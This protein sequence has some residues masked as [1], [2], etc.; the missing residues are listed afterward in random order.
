VIYL[1]YNASTPIDPR[2]LGAML[3]VFEADFANASSSHAMG[4]AAAEL[5][6]EAR[7]RVG[8]LAGTRSRSVI[9]TSGATEAAALAIEGILATSPRRRILVG[10][11]EHKAVL[12]AAARSATLRGT[13]VDTVKVDRCGRIDLDQVGSLLDDNVA[14][15]AIMIA[16]NETGTVNDPAAVA[17]M[18]HDNGALLLC[19]ATQAAGK[20]PLRLEA[21]GVDLALMSAHKM[22]GPKGVGALV[23]DRSV[24]TQL[25]PLIVGGGQERGLRGGTLNTPGIVGFGHA[26]ALAIKELDHDASDASALIMHLRSKLEASLSGITL[27]GDVDAR[28][29]NTANLRFEGADADAVMVAMPGVA[30]SSGS[31]CQ[32]AVPGPS[33]V[34]AAMG[35]SAD[36]ASES[37]RFSVGRPT[38]GTEVDAAVEQIIHAVGRIRALSDQ[39]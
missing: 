13:Q 11:T 14:L 6:E 23:V 36:A 37:I 34:L 9:F 20:I 2:V 8:L 30:V 16:N 21:A 31:A 35:L 18:V 3:P 32:S 17:D 10:A 4:Q 22:Y 1:D 25:A 33:H 28:L 29:P 19:D 7:E 27:N 26:A 24:Q 15:V 5:V 38:T 39:N 12:E